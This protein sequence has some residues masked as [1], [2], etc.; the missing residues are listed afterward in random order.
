MPPSPGLVSTMPAADLA[1]SVAVDTAIP[2]CAWRNAGASLAPSPHI[3]TL[4]PPFWNALTSLY[5]SSGRTPAKT[6]NCSGVTA[7][8]IGPGGQTAPS[9]PT[10]RAT[11]AAVAGASPVT[12]TVRTPNVRIS[13]TN[14]AESARGGSLSAISPA[15]RIAAAVP[16]AT[17]SSL[18]PFASSSVAAADNSGN[19]RRKADHCGISSLHDPHGAAPAWIHGS[20]LGRLLCGIEGDELNQFRQLGALARGC[21]ANR[22]ID[23]ILPAVRSSLAPQVP[24]SRPRRSSARDGLRSPSIRCASACRSCRRTRHRWLPLRP[25]PRAASEA[26]P[27]APARV[28]PAQPQRVNVAGSAT[29]IDA[30]IAVSTSGTISASGI[31]S[32]RHTPPA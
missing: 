12:I 16:V 21:G 5:L 20:R 28:R 27:S 25:R 24:A 9:S 8:P 2:I 14:A 31:A 7:S 15:R 3:A 32:R 26:R 6:A 13:A 18:K 30:R 17:A 22:C 10:A 1:T 4:W 29:G 23:R 11:I 19:W